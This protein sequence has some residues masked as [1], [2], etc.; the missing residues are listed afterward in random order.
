[1]VRWAGQTAAN[2]TWV[3]LSEFKQ[4]YPSFKLTD[5]LV[6]QGEM[7]CAAFNIPTEQGRKTATAGHQSKRIKDDL[8]VLKRI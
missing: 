2:A 8:R 3:E 4:L 7:L 5:E 1:L 6:V